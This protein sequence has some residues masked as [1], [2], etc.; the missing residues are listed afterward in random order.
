MKKSLIFAIVGLAAG[1]VS[2]F[3]QGTINFNSYYADG[4]GS[5]LTQITFGAGT[6]GLQGSAV[7]AG[8][9]ADVYY[10]LSA[11]S[12]T[13]GNGVLNGL[14]LASGSGSP[15]TYSLATSMGSIA[16]PAGYFSPA[17]YFTL[18]PYS[19]QTVYFEVVVYQTGQTYDT[20]TIRGHSDVFSSTLATGL[21]TAPYATYGSFTVSQVTVVP[22]PSTLALAGLGGFGMLMALRRKKA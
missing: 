9:T 3:A 10:S 2:S 5:G 1:A 16:V 14:L 12:D 19:N 4:V 17:N 7:G 15:S 8:Y 18:N 20:S 6:G 22:E 11:F 13:A 21:N